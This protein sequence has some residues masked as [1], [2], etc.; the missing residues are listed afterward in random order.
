LIQ[1]VASSG[2]PKAKYRTTVEIADEFLE[3]SFMAYLE[4]PPK[5]DNDLERSDDLEEIIYKARRKALEKK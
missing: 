1:A 3:S 4:P 5:E 2:P